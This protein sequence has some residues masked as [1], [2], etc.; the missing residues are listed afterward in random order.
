MILAAYCQ[1]RIDLLYAPP[2]RHVPS[3]CINRFP[4]ASRSDRPSY[5]GEKM[6]PAWAQRQVELWRDCLVSPNVFQHMVDR[7]HD[8]AVPSQHALATEASPRNVPLDL[9]GLWAHLHRQNAET[10]AAL[11]EVKRLLIQGCL[12]TASWEPRPLVH[13]LVGQSSSR[14]G[15]SMASSPSIPAVCLNAALT[16]GASSANGI[17]CN[18]G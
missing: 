14:C 8:V 12:G 3:C 11:V 10:I 16:R 17:T 15:H 13:V 9:T 1:C 4:A 6:T 18:C 5:G 7:L 2:L